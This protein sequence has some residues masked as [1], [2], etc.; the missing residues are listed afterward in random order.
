VLTLTSSQF[1]PRV[2]RTFLRDR[3]T[4]LSLAIYTATFTYSVLVLR[5]VRA[6]DENGQQRFVPA[7]A[8]TV[9]IALL[10]LSVAMFVVHI[11]DLASSVLAR[12][13]A[14]CPHRAVQRFHTSITLRRAGQ[15]D[16]VTAHRRPKFRAGL[17]PQGRPGWIASKEPRPP[18]GSRLV[19]LSGVPTIKLNRGRHIASPTALRRA[20]PTGP[21]PVVDNA[22]RAEFAR[23]LHADADLAGALR[24]QP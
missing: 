12:P 19:R 3:V 4:Q 14:G 2:L 21:S 7:I 22:T 13:R 6:A 11:P 16:A 24:L 18:S 15:P 20:W 1:S 17:L 9:G 8:T 5:T 10:L 23:Q